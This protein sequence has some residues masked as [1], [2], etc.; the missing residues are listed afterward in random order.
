MDKKEKG[1]EDKFLGLDEAADDDRPVVAKSLKAK[2]TKQ[3]RQ[4][5]KGKRN[6]KNIWKRLGVVVMIFF[7]GV[8]VVLCIAGIVRVPVLSNILYQTPSPS[9]VVSDVVLGEIDRTKNGVNFDKESSVLSVKISE[10]YLSYFLQQLQLKSNDPSFDQN[11][12]VVVESGEIEFYATMLRPV[13]TE[14]TLRVKPDIGSGLSLTKFFKVTKFKVGNLRLPSFVAELYL[15]ELIE[16]KLK[17]LTSA[18]GGASNLITAKPPV[19]VK[20]LAL[21]NGYAEIDIYFDMAKIQENMKQ[22]PQLLEEIQ[23]RYPAAASK[24]IQP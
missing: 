16:S 19:S 20:N 14:I 4:I 11:I 13:K 7:V 10:E 6:K 15:K 23:K 18:F 1:F 5:K 17:T 2:K 21:E 9:R 12:Q 22:L 24:T 8:L 3:P